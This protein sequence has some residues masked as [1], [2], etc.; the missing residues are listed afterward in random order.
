MRLLHFLCSRWN[1]ILPP[2]ATVALYAFTG[3]EIRLNLRYPSQLGREGMEQ[4]PP[5]TGVPLVIA[6]R[7]GKAPRGRVE[8]VPVLLTPGPFAKAMPRVGKDAEQLYVDHTAGLF[9]DPIFICFRRLC[10]EFQS[11]GPC[12]MPAAL[13]PVPPGSTFQED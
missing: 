13:V 1:P 2:P 8:I 6:Q 3:T 4:V 9:F 10:A 12:I 7:W 5:L 11:A